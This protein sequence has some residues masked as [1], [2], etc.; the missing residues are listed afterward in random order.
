MA[1]LVETFPIPSAEGGGGGWRSFA[2]VICI[3]EGIT[4]GTKSLIIGMRAAMI[5]C[6]SEFYGQASLVS[7]IGMGTRQLSLAVDA[8]PDVFC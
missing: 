8:A 5:K 7:A 2:R 1:G 4:S 6:Q 3:D